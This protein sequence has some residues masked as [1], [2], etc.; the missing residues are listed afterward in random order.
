MFSGKF[1]LGKVKVTRLCRDVTTEQERKIAL[2]R[3]INGDWG[4]VSKNTR[5]ANNFDLILE[6]GR[7]RSAYTTN[8]GIRFR[9][10]TEWDRSIT[11]ILLSGESCGAN[12]DSI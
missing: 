3:H 7:L 12:Q 9:I 8:D 1:E 4:E 5:A 6:G 10:V 2:Q 11:T